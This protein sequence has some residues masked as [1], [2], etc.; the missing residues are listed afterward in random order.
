MQ[1]VDLKAQNEELLRELEASK[2]QVA[3]LKKELA[4][5]GPAVEQDPAELAE[6]VSGAA[7][8]VERIR[9]LLK[10]ST[11][12]EALQLMD[13]LKEAESEFAEALMRELECE[14]LQL[15]EQL[16]KQGGD[17]GI[18]VREQ[19]VTAELKLVECR[20]RLGLPFAVHSACQTEGVNEAERER[21]WAECVDYC[22][23]LG[24]ESWA[25]YAA[26]GEITIV[27]R[28]LWR[29][30]QTMKTRMD[31][32]LHNQATEAAYCVMHLPP[33]IYLLK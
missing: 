15:R 4:N 5:A 26:S 29:S 31:E 1:I 18:V 13:K 12:E 14:V 24:N 2:A 10:N 21:Q 11:G 9:Q 25:E 23:S 32:A 30:C 3:L 6:A 22:G 7:D 27:V 20:E 16:K 8:E 28:E 19:L 17:K 33:H